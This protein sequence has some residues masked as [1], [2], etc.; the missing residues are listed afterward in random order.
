MVV[1]LKVKKIIN[2]I[3]KRKAIPKLE[4]SEPFIF[5]GNTYVVQSVTQS[6]DEI[7][8]SG[9]HVVRYLQD[10]ILKEEV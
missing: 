9:V 3:F 1:S 5:R 7:S 8:L 10:N 2:R 6:M 4:L